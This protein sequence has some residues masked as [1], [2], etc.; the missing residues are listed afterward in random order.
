MPELNFF[1]AGENAEAAAD[2]LKAALPGGEEVTVRR[3]EPKTR[4]EMRT[5]GVLNPSDLASLIVS[6]PSAALAVR[7]VA[8]RIK[9]RHDSEAVI[10]TAKRLEAG[11]TDTYLLDAYGTH[12]PVANLDA[13]RLLHLASQI[14]LSPA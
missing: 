7:N 4:H 10:E 13:D 6:I 3:H 8:D 5:R 14:D 2:Q 9:R 1:I 11:G 12:R